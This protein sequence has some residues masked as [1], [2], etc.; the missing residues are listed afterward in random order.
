MASVSE[1]LNFDRIL[2]TGQP[3]ILSLQ[4]IDVRVDLPT[5][6]LGFLVVVHKAE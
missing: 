3:D 6:R 4:S 5:S 1:T 2:S